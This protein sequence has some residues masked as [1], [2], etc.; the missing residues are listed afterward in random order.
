VFPEQP[1][2]RLRWWLGVA[3]LFILV[4]LVYVPAFH[5]G[6]IWDDDRYVTH[7][8][9]LS[10]PDGLWKIWFSAEQPSQYFP[11]TYSTLY[12]EH[13][14]WGASATGYHVANI[15]LHCFNALLV[16]VLLRRLALPGAW[17]GAALFAVHPVQVE[18]VAWISELKNLQSTFFFLLS[19][20]AWMNFTQERERKQWLFY[21]W[22]LLLY[23][24]ALASKTTA[25]TLPAV[26]LLVL[27]LQKR[28]LGWRTAA[29]VAPFCVLGLAAG[30]AAMWWERHLG[31]NGNEDGLLPGFF[32]RLQIP[33]RALWF[34]AAKLVWPFGLSFSY[35]RWDLSF[36][37]LPACLWTAAWGLA[38]L[39]LWLGRHRFGRGPLAV[40][41]FYTTTLLPMLGFFQNYTFRYSLVADHYQYLACIG[42]LAALVVVLAKTSERWGGGLRLFLVLQSVALLALGALTWKQCGIYRDE[43][44][45]WHDT[46]ARNPDSFL[47]CDNLGVYYYNHHQLDESVR[48]LKQASTLNPKGFESFNNLGISLAA[49]RHLDDAISN[50][51]K[52][53]EI[54][55]TYSIAYGNLGN[56][57]AK[58]G[59][60][61]EALANYQKALQIKPNDI[62]V[63]NSLA[64][65]FERMGHN[66]EAAGQYRE[67]LSL[68]PQ[69][70]GIMGDLALLLATSR[71]AQVRNGSEALRLAKEACEL[72]QYREPARLSTL[73]AAYAESG[74]FD[75]A[76]M[77][78]RKAEELAISG[79]DQERVAI[80]RQLKAMFLSHRPLRL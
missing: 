9:L 21:W 58:K 71:D 4:G 2:L 67:I 47:A 51:C 75:E 44:T 40:F 6:F 38:G 20:L 37:V 50:Y 73:A 74:Q 5:A 24:L 10:A 42:P 11:L 45:L 13:A 77:T 76:A 60:L 43:L 32:Q 48:Y 14:L 15:V 35:P 12:V 78:A 64:Q 53:L 41:L 46:L 26:L 36:Q 52:A 27:W 18:S 8:A 49:Q 80:C 63:R 29:E 61:D 7:N 19:L 72:T 79:G 62:L 30:L 69:N 25:C 23:C 54:A 16:W 39:G 17:F 22:S 33:G 55:P 66:R 34:Y 1:P 56:A 68:D 65:L 31:H 57:L 3:G 59:R 28:P 70:S